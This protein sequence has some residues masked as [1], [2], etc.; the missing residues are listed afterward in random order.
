MQHLSKDCCPTAV[1]SDDDYRTA[2]AG[3]PTFVEAPMEYGEML[4][5]TGWTVSAR[6]DVTNEYDETFRNMFGHEKA[7]RDEFERVH[8]AEGAAELM[9]RRERTIKALDRN[10]LRREIF[11]AVRAG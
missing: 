1:V 10:L 4:E 3:G 7:N 6:T 5:Q 9:A 8:G 2:A 11:T